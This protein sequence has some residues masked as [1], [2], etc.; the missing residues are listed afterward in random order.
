MLRKKV[1]AVD[2]DDD[3]RDLLVNMLEAEGCL[4]DA[5]EDGPGH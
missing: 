4:V 5:A 1:L 3:V 2:D